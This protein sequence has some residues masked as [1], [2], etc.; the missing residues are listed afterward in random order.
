MSTRTQV[1]PEEKLGGVK[2]ING[3][4]YGEDII[5]GVPIRVPV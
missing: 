3:M 2:E 1:A 5:L 4:I